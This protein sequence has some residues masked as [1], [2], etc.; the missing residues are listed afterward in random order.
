MVKVKIN[1]ILPVCIGEGGSSCIYLAKV[2]LTFINSTDY[3]T[4]LQNDEK[5][6]R[7]IAIKKLKPGLE[8]KLAE[9]LRHEKSIVGTLKGGTSP[10]IAKYY[11]TEEALDSRNSLL[12]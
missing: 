5:V 1:T 7:Y 4:Y 8:N 12:M 2:F 11:G 9:K 6:E 10:F 3:W